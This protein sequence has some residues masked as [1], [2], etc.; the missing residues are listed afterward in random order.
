MA[1]N[2]WYR[3]QMTEI[4]AAVAAGDDK[5]LE[6]AL[7]NTVSESTDSVESILKGLTDNAPRRRR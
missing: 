3:S 1:D 2:K 4:Q 7:A 6:K 5:R